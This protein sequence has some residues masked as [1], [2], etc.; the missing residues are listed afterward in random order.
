M[1]L[2]VLSPLLF[3][4]LGLLINALFGQRMG[5]R[6]VGWTASLAVI[7]SFV[8][9]VAL[10]AQV[11]QSHGAAI[12]VS[13]APWIAAGALN[14]S[15]GFLVDPLSSVMMLIVTGVGALIHIY[16]IGYMHGDA[17]FRRYF[18]YLNLFVASM[19]LL[20]MADNFLVLF[21]G[22]ELVGLCSYLL[23][24]FWFEDL[25]NAAAGRKA[26]IVN[27]IGD[28][29][30]VLGILLIFA[31]FGTLDFEG[32]FAQVKERGEA[33]A[34]VAGAITLLLFIG[35]TG[36]SAQIPLFVWLPDAM[37]GPTPVSALIHAATMVTAGV[38]M[39][40]RAHALFGLAPATQT[41]VAIVGAATALVAASSA[42]RQMD[43]K[44]VLA[45]STV[46]QLGFMV[47]AAGLGVYVA[48][49]F[50]L[51]THAFFKALLFL[52]A[53][54]VIH[55]MHADHHS[56]LDPQDMRN[57]GGLARRM[58]IT[59]ATFVV[60]GLALAGVPPLAGFFSKDEILL[61]A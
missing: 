57:M 56:N 4:L 23:I 11:G 18:V 14:V 10:F 35:A 2:L 55:A 42:L 58:P 25:K 7:A 1:E 59:F 16:S 8:A 3:P 28:V 38:Y 51:L 6:A 15:W 49:L 20:V 41:L 46:S 52:G 26:F 29:G 54:S 37:A 27:R 47:A 61:A 39:M 50:H 9:A 44:K 32:V 48:S 33:L 43:I 30:F 24:G 19:L 5:E 17:R 31:T 12:R 21:V 13:I 45:Y 60:G 34:A 22:W 40:S 36:K 53:G